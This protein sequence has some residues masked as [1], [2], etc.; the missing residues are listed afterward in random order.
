MEIMMRIFTSKKLAY[1]V[2]IAL[3]GALAGCG[4]DGKD[5]AP[6]Q[7]GDPGQPGKP[8]DPW[9]PPPVT[10]SAVTNVKVLGYSFGEGSITYEFEVTD[11]NGNLVNGDRK[12]VV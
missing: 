2:A 9:T 4:S 8:G 1:L 5:G 6:G 10:S 7:P 12:S 3:T 11:E